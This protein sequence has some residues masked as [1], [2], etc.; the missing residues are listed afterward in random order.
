M[1]KKII[2]TTFILAAISTIS[3]NGSALHLN[4][5]TT[6]AIIPLE[7]I[8]NQRKIGGITNVN[9]SQQ[10]ITIDDKNGSFTYYYNREQ[11]K[12][13]NINNTNTQTTNNTDTTSTDYTSTNGFETEICNLVNQYRAQNNLSAV[14][15]SNDLS[16]MAQAKAEDMATQ[17]YFDHTSPTYGDPFSMMSTF[18]I[19][20]KY[21]GEN[22]AK[23]QKTPESVM[24]AWMNS[25]GHKANILNKTFT[26]I[27]VGY[28]INNGTTYWTQEFIYR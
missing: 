6:K 26:E 21:A 20:Y 14:K 23:G 7:E 5:N 18:G 19:N 13:Q 15:L 10:N 11:A 16:K 1:F 4:N 27:G 2:A 25:E 22:I 9:P 24:N 3:V 17:N 28:A 12:E 8:Q